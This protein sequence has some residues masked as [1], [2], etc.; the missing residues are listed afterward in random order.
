MIASER[1]CVFYWVTMCA[2]V[3]FTLCVWAN[4]D[5]PNGYHVQLAAFADASQADAEIKGLESNGV[6][7]VAIFSE[8][9]LRKVVAGDYPTESDAAYA[10]DYWKTHG[11]QEAIVIRTGDPSTSISVT[12]IRDSIGTP[13][14]LGE[15]REKILFWPGA[16]DENLP[17]PIP[18]QRD[19]NLVSADNATLCEDDLWRKCCMFSKDEDTSLA[20][21][22]LQSF[23]ATFPVSSHVPECQLM[24]GKWKERTGDRTGAEQVFMSLRQ[25][26][27]QSPEAGAASVRLGVFAKERG[28]NER[29][30]E[31]F[32]SVLNRI[33]A[34]SRQAKQEAAS[35][36]LILERSLSQSDSPQLALLKGAYQEFR[37]GNRDQAKLKFQ[38][39]VTKY[40][41][42][43][44]AGE[45]GLRL[46][47]LHWKAKNREEALRAF[48]SII[49]GKVRASGSAKAE[50]LFR[51]ARLLHQ[52]KE[53]LQALRAY[54]E[55]SKY[56]DR[57]G[58]DLGVH[59]EILGLLFELSEGIAGNKD[60]VRREAEMILAVKP[61]CKVDRAYQALASLILVET[62]FAVPEFDET[63][64]Q[65]TRHLA[66]FPEF[67][68]E[69]ELALY[70]IGRTY[71]MKS[72]YEKARQYFARILEE[73][74]TYEKMFAG[75]NT[76]NEAQYRLAESYYKLGDK[77]KAR[78]I[79]HDL[80]S[81]PDASSCIRDAAEWL[82]D[83]FLSE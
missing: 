69:R 54:R 8:G 10:R 16:L 56:T 36:L 70:Y 62:Y 72:N 20:V 12:E 73:N 21:Q 52:K 76:K 65:A 4:G 43:V 32:R 47:Y 33:S 48:R 14:D 40:P 49:E 2:L 18:P 64:A 11:Y 78:D 63:I 83:N 3:L 6:S 53:R 9:S 38:E 55:L 17:T 30:L 66:Q 58:I 77:Q 80:L 57:E 46:G 1:Q 7:A 31:L 26:F 61:L 41:N 68:R 50:A 29:A 22:S 82:L 71:Y 81:K 45:A 24:L 74:L 75:E 67:P 27:P 25:G 39:V 13:Y 60:D 37:K 44:E 79:I 5:V 59:T 23:I 34:A 28:E 51:I 15:I 19:P 35:Q 42:A